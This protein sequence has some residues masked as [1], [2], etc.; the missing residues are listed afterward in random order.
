M[1]S[2]LALSLCLNF[3]LP[4]FGQSIT[5]S[6]KQTYGSFLMSELEEIQNHIAEPSLAKVTESFPN[7]YGSQITLAVGLRSNS[8]VGVFWDYTSTGGRMAYQDYSGKLSSDLLV[9]RNALGL[10][11]EE[12]LRLNEAFSL[13]GGLQFSALFS[14]LVI[15]DYLEV[16]DERQSQVTHM[17]ALGF[18]AEPEVALQFTKYRVLCRVGMG[19]QLSFSKPFQNTQNLFLVVND[20]TVEPE[21]SGFRVGFTL[22]YE[23]PLKSE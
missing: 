22:G 21:W 23:I 20:D 11:Y 9:S 2:L 4:A 12:I 10:R 16:Y 7:Y 1:K 18:G 14:R 6:V 17:R 8:N 3:L 15:Q 13:V 5:L 19:Y